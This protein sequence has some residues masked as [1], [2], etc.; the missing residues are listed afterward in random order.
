MS[1]LVTD[2]CTGFWWAELIWPIHQ[3]CVEHDFGGTDGVLLD[4][5]ITAGVP[6]ALA[7]FAVFGMA[8]WRPVYEA[9]L[10]L[11]SWLTRIVN[12]D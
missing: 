9:W 8:F 2:G 3:C 7:A 4:C 1:A 5:I 11:K 10:G 12:R 6:A